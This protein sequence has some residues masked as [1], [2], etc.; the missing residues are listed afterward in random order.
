MNPPF[1]QACA[2]DAPARRVV[3]MSRDPSTDPILSAT[4]MIRRVLDEYTSGWA[5]AA[6]LKITRAR[7][8]DIRNATDDPYLLEKVESLSSWLG[9]LF[10]ARKH[11]KHG[12]PA[13][14]K[15]HVLDDL[16]RLESYARRGSG[17]HP[18]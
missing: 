6:A 11:Q 4:G 13:T 9:I 7:V 8:S 14:A 10:S 12:G 5:N 3:R 1:A 18:L 17:Q 15:Q 2:A 16:S